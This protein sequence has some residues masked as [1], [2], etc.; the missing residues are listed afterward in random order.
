MCGGVAHRLEQA[1][2]NH[3]VAG[4]IPA[5]PTKKM[6]TT[7]REW[8]LFSSRACWNRTSLLSWQKW[9]VQRIIRAEIYFE[10]MMSGNREP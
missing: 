8:S 1:A 4:S 5:A 7:P 10:H 3:L 9:F 6:K 2:H